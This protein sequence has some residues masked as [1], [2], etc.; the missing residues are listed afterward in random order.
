MRVMVIKYMVNCDDILK[1]LNELEARIAKLESKEYS[2]NKIPKKPQSLVEF[3]KQLKL[4]S[5]T[6]K[7]LAILYYYENIKKITPITYKEILNGYIEARE[8]R[9]KNLSNTLYQNTVRV[10]IIYSND[11]NKKLKEYTMTN[12]S[13]DF[14]TKKLNII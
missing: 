1:R 3:I 8:K 9:P 4:K 14:I 2:D 11:K 10:Y 7:T 5:F 13:N 12:N 6:Y